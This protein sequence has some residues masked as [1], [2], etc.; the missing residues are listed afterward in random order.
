MGWGGGLTP[1]LFLFLTSELSLSF[2]SAMVTNDGCD[3]V[4]FCV[5]T[6]GMPTGLKKYVARWLN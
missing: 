5:H 2:R 6:V 4:S 1:S 3:S